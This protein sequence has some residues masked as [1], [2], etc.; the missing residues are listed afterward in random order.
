MSEAPNEVEAQAPPDGGCTADSA[1]VP[2]WATAPPEIGAWLLLECAGAWPAKILDGPP[3][4][5]AVV[6]RL[7]AIDRG[8]PDVRVQLVRRP[9]RDREPPALFLAR[10]SGPERWVN[11]LSLKSHEAL[12]DLDVLGMI[13]GT[14]SVPGDK[15]NESL[16]L[17]C[18][19]GKRD[20]CCALYGA[21][22][23][24]TLDQSLGE[25]VWQTSHLG[26]HRF[27]TVMAILPR[28]LYLGRVKPEEAPSF[29]SGLDAGH[30]PPADRVRGQAGDPE[31]VQAAEHYLRAARGERRLDAIGLVSVQ[32]LDTARWR[33]ALRRVGERGPVEVEIVQ[34]VGDPQI[35]PSC[36]KA[37]APTER[38]EL[39]SMTEAPP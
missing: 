3:L 30:L 1:A 17:V 22:V 14:V 11:R 26:G 10:S 29:V 18:V 4:P 13:D 16:T 15:L 36:D 2:L 39:V 32:A 34:T 19:H 5:A 24:R 38:F 12:L 7:K 31:P 20:R 33:V 8:R 6:D 28:G 35:R 25:R 23:F 27:S 21:S 9:R 37:P